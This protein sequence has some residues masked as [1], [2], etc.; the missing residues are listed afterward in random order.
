MSPNDE[1]P[2][3]ESPAKRQLEEG[4]SKMGRFASPEIRKIVEDALAKLDHTTPR[5]VV[6]LLPPETAI[7]Y[8]YTA[9]RVQTLVPLIK[10]AHESKCF[11]ET[12]ILGHGI[13][14]FA[15]RGLYVM[16]W[17]RAIMP[18]PLTTDQLAPYYKKPSRLGDVYRLI[19]DLE[20]NDLLIKQQA[21][22]LR[23]ANED[24]NK[25]AHGVIFGEIVHADLEESSQK[26][27]WAA[28]GAI[29]RFNAWFNNPLPLKII[30]ILNKTKVEAGG[31][32]TGPQSPEK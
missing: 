25:A 7:F 17:Q 22:F 19:G 21:T 5:K 8:L 14:Q 32:P 20:N 15:L 9:K 30:P 28:R 18:T 16:A 11:V 23:K 24:R 2:K 3:Y 27:H 13:I 26:C 31:R 12:I 4:L 6:Q 29:D 1:E 10:H